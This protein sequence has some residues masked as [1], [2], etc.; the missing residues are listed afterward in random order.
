M[1]NMNKMPENMRDREKIEYVLITAARNEEK[2]IG[3]TIKSV[4]AQNILPRRWV[5]A[6]DGSTDRTHEIVEHY[7]KMHD[8]IELIKTAPDSDRNFGSKARAVNAAYDRIRERV[9]YDY[10]GNLD[11]DVS[12]APDYYEKIADTFRKHPKLGISGGI[13]FDAHRTDFV[14]QRL[15]TQWSVSGPVQMFRKECFE[16]IGGYREV[17][18]GV[19]A[20]AEIMARMHGWEVRTFPEIHALHLRPT[21]REGRGAFAAAFKQGV[22]DF[23]IGYH[24]VFVSFKCLNRISRKPFGLSIIM[25]AGYTWAALRRKPRQIPRHVVFFLRREQMGRL[26][27][28]LF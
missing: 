16:D 1:T 19:D 9:H 4:I 5:I 7:A 23:A 26:K 3:M 6:S 17:S 13:L 11:A 10:V 24:P 21:G 18:G 12:F 15:S 27:N 20:V 28:Y 2:Y 8:F 25:L 14:R 22:E